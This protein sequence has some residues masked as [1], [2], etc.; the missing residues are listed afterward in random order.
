VIDNFKV[1]LAKSRAGKLDATSFDDVEVRI[2]KEKLHVKHLAQI[3]PK[4]TLSV[5]VNPYDSDNLEA[6]EK[7]IKA[8]DDTL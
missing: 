5:I 4:N 2:G 7:S 3:A 6:I 1:F 8:S